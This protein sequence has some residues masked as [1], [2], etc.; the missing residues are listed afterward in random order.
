MH[1]GHLPALP[2][3]P[4]GEG[5]HA[6][7]TSVRFAK[8]LDELAAF[9]ADLHPSAGEGVVSEVS[10]ALDRTAPDLMAHIEAA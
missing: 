3:C 6:G 9:S 8:R 1:V 5:G 4:P 7:D 10:A 2:R